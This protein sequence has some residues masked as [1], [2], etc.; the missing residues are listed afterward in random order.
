VSG[1]RWK[2][3]NHVPRLLRLIRVRPNPN[4]SLIFPVRK[5]LPICAC[6]DGAIEYHKSAEK[7]VFLCE[8]GHVIT[9]GS[10]RRVCDHGTARD[11]TSVSSTSVRPRC[12]RGGGTSHTRYATTATRLKLYLPFI[13]GP[14][15][16]AT[17]SST[18]LFGQ[19]QAIKWRTLSV[20][21]RL[22]Q[23]G[24]TLFARW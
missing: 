17:A 15:C 13:P 16:Q 5:I 7:T 9:S 4:P 18:L 14:Q 21:Q 10:R 22:D 12:M 8:E 20:V 11:R 2:K 6:T 3:W 1:S 23:P 24:T 19:L